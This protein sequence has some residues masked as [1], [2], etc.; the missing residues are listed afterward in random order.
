LVIKNRIF[1]GA[2]RCLKDFK[3]K[4]HLCLCLF[5][6]LLSFEF[7]FRNGLS[8]P[9]M[10]GSS[11]SFVFS[12]FT[13]LSIIISIIFVRS[14]NLLDPLVFFFIPPTLFGHFLSLIIF[15]HLP[16]SVGC[17]PSQGYFQ[18]CVRL[19][20]GLQRIYFSLVKGLSKMAFLHFKL[21]HLGSVSLTFMWVCKMISHYSFK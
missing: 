1:A 17:D 5:L 19:K 15:L 20:K 21:M 16:L 11:S 7:I 18:K 12:F 8:C 6:D 14:S 4:D 3:T 2:K 13:W 10:L 9:P